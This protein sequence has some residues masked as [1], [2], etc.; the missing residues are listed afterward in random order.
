MVKRLG[1]AASACLLALTFGGCSADSSDPEATPSSPGTT[2]AAP[3]AP[4]ESASP[5]F[6]DVPAD[7]DESP[8]GPPPVPDAE[9]TDEDLIALLRTRATVGS[10]EHCRPDQ[11]RAVLS[12]F[13]MAAGH[14]ATRITVHNVSDQACLVEGVPGIGVRGAWGRTFVP[15]VGRG[16]GSLADPDAVELAPGAAA[17]STLEWTGDL[18]GAESEHASLVVVQLAKGQVPV[19]VPARLENDPADAPSLDIG[20]LTTLRLTPFVAAP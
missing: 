8:D 6:E 13:D 2:P 14:R 17:T 18:A 11:V 7:A 5:G 3:D 12:G 20:T 19:A 9:L 15:G 1:A 16:S 10:T 4:A